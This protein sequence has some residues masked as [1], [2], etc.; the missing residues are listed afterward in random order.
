MRKYWHYLQEH[1]IRG[2]HLAT[3][4]NRAREFFLSVDFHVLFE[5]KRNFLEPYIREEVKLII[6][7]KKFL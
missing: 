5:V 4:S 1:K 2:V 3:M 6:L 7:G